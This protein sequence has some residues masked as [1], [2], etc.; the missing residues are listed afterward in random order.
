MKAVSNT[1]P[2][3]LL[4]K[5]GH[6]WI[7]EKLFKEVIIPPAV[8]KEWLRPGGH[9]V[10]QWLT[11]ANLPSNA[12]HNADKLSMN[13]DR[14]EAEAIA[15][16][17]TI[18]ADWLLL[19]DLKGRKQAKSLGLPVVGTI[20]ILVTAKRKGIIPELGLIINTLK[21]HRYYLSDDVL[22]KALILAGERQ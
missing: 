9:K 11:V 6:L 16:F 5:A 7:L 14:G 1:S 8:D 21:K 22:E 15:L 19:D 18:K 10:P 20:G 17:E 2:N 3:I 4:E 13:L 12:K